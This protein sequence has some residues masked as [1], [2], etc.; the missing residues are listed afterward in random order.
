MMKKQA[1]I[2]KAKTMAKNTHGASDGENSEEQ[3]HDI[4]S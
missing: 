1:D 3:S 4:N 2:K